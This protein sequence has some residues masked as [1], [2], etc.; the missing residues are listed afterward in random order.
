MNDDGEASITTG[1]GRMFSRDE[2]WRPLWSNSAPA[3]F[4]TAKTGGVENYFI[5]QSWDLTVQ[6]VGYLKTLKA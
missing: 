2:W 6:G 1:D 4:A 3:I 5:E